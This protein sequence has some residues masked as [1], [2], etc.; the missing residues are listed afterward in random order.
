MRQLIRTSTKRILKEQ[1]IVLG[2]VIWRIVQP[3][4]LPLLAGFVVMYLIH[5]VLEA[6]EI[7]FLSISKSVLPAII[8][9]YLIE[10]VMERVFEQ[11]HLRRFRRN[12]VHI[13]IRIFASE[14]RARANSIGI[15]VI[16]TSRLKQTEDVAD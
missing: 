8:A 1:F 4:L 6:F 7:H 15:V 10:K 5:A 16:S 12:C 9:A 2:Q 11:F 13:A 14:V 3:T